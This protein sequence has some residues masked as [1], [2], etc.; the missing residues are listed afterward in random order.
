[1]EQDNR[2][3]LLAK[4]KARSVSFVCHG[5]FNPIYGRCP[6]QCEYCYQHLDYRSALDKKLGHHPEDYL[7]RL[8]LNEEAFKT[9]LGKDKL[10]LV[11]TS[12]DMF[13]AP[14]KW[15]E[16]ALDFLR[17]FPSNRY[18]F[19]SKNPARI[20][21]FLDK[22]PEGSMLS[23]TIETDAYQTAGISKAPS[24]AMRAEAFKS[25]NWPLKML[26]VSPVLPFNSDRFLKMICEI[27]A[28]FLYMKPLDDRPWIGPPS[29]RESMKILE[30]TMRLVDHTDVKFLEG[31]RWS[32]DNEGRFGDGSSISPEAETEAVL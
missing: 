7:G 31:Y 15:I 18:E 13:T 14:S 2:S 9:D 19:C 28:G 10:I 29:W 4:L 26:C 30:L 20:A 23:C 5:V 21:K 8:K 11:S 16:R 1:M 17:D 32:L 25:L 22:I 27:S 6:Y 24:P 12:N 3:R